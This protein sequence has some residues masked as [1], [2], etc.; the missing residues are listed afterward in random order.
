[1]VARI[2]HTSM[3]VARIHRTVPQESRLQPVWGRNRLKPGLP[4]R[5]RSPMTNPFQTV[6]KKKRHP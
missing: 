5:G 4:F 3:M 6:S 2:G 1:M